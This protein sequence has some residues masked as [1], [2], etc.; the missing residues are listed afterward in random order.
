MAHR[1]RGTKIAIGTTASDAANDTYKEIKNARVLSGN[2]G[3]AWQEADATVLTDSYRKIAKTV[4]DGG[5]IEIGGL[6]ES[7]AAP[8]E[9][10]A[11]L[12]AA[13]AD[14]GDAPYNFQITLTSGRL[15]H[16]KAKVMSFQVSV[17]GVQN[18][19]EF[20]SRLS[21]QTAFTES[22]SAE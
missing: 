15:I 12:Q 7:S 11:A 19:V 20:R 8:D 18:L 21:V 16:L 1:S 5:S 10:Q 4:A 2:L 14:D 6:Y 13:A 17:G 3:P 9:G 22:A